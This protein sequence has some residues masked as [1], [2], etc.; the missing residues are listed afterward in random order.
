MHFKARLFDRLG[1][2]SIFSTNTLYHAF[3]KYV[4]VKNVNY[5]ES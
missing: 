2:N 5:R 4:V 1:F 3:D